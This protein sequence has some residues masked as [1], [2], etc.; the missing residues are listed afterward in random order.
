MKSIQPLPDEV[1]A[2]INS[3]VNSDLAEKSVGREEVADQG[4]FENNR[5]SV[6]YGWTEKGNF[7]RSRHSYTYYQ[8]EV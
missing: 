1:T 4:K 6:N 5:R 2:V 3:A 8:S 7:K